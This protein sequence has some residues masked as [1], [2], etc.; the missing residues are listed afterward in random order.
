MTWLMEQLVKELKGQPITLLVVL[1]LV[2]YSAFSYTNHASAAELEVIAGQLASIE[3]VNECRWLSDKISDLQTE[4]YILERDGADTAWINEKKNELK[5]LE[6]RY[7]LTT[8][9]QTGY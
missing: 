9:S 1:A 3:K 7:K 5:R 2:G 4:I 8:C 6:S